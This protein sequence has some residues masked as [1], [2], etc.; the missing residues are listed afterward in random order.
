M[1]E[2]VT[3]ALALAACLIAYQGIAFYKQ[4]RR[5]IKEFFS[6]ARPIIDKMREKVDDE[7]YVAEVMGKALVGYLPHDTLFDMSK[8]IAQHCVE[9]SLPY[10]MDRVEQSIPNLIASAFSSDL[11]RDLQSKS[12]AA[13][14]VVDLEGNVKGKQALQFGLQKLLGGVNIPLDQVIQGYKALKEL[15]GVS[16]E[17]RQAAQQPANGVVI[18]Y[19]PPKALEVGRA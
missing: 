9:G 14:T 19:G 7:E 15:E 13:R 12:V 1:I 6:E 17:Q 5:Q 10:V 8:G 2:W 16:A 18:D 4:D 11:A 3:L